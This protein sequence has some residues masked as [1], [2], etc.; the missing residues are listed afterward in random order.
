[1]RTP[2]EVFTKKIQPELACLSQEKF[3]GEFQ[4]YCSN[5]VGDFVEL[6]K[7]IRNYLSCLK[8]GK[9]VRMDYKVENMTMP[10]CN[11]ET[12]V[13]ITFSCDLHLLASS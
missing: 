11:K 7:I 6:L 3:F 13:V 4:V 5:K 12:V 9:Y 2:Q 10:P 8:Y 1:M